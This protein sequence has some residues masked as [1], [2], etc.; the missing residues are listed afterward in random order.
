M[1]YRNSRMYGSLRFIYVTNVTTRQFNGIHSFV[2]TKYENWHK[3]QAEGNWAGIFR[4]D[5]SESIGLRGIVWNSEEPTDRAEASLHGIAAR[6]SKDWPDRSS[7]LLQWYWSV[8]CCK[9]HNGQSVN[10]TTESNLLLGTTRLLACY[11]RT[12]P[13]NNNTHLT[14]G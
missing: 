3:G 8:L 4:R 1:E 9:Q 13:P 12:L 2:S 7:R 6:P 5:K 14:V 11:W 10:G